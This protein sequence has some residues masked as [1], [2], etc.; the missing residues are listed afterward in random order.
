MFVIRFLIAE[1]VVLGGIIGGGISRDVSAGTIAWICFG[2]LIVMQVAVVIGI[3]VAANRPA[4]RVATKP[5]K[6]SDR[7]VPA[8]R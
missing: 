2:A 4:R 5:T 7:L 1:L 3:A 8:H 6:S